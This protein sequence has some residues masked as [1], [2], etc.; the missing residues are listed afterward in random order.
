[1][2]NTHNF[3]QFISDAELCAFVHAQIQTILVQFKI[4]V[5]KWKIFIRIRANS[6]CF[7]LTLKKFF[8]LFYPA[9]FCMYKDGPANFFSNAKLCA[10]VHAQ[11]HNVLNLHKRIFQFY[12]AQ[13]CMSVNFFPTLKLNSSQFC[14]PKNGRT[15]LFLTLKPYA[16]KTVRFCACTNINNF[17]SIEKIGISKWNIYMISA[18]SQ[19]VEFT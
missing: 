16:S 4:V 11:T 1:M 7:E 15:I 12:L 17:S 13:F 19:Y 2:Y 9:Q 8:F 6:H 18:N 14:M 10:F 5:L 3:G